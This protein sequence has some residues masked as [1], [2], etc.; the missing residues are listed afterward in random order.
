MVPK[1][2]SIQDRAAGPDLS[3]AV[4]ELEPPLLRQ[5]IGDNFSDTVSVRRDREAL[6]EVATGRR[7]TWAELEGDVD[8]LAAKLALS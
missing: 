5:T 8:A 7:W 1:R 4:G 6:V 3:H 2:S